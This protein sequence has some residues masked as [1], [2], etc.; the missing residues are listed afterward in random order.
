MA[1]AIERLR[2]AL[3]LQ[4]RAVEPGTRVPVAV[5]PEAT[6]PV[7][8]AE[9][10]L[11]SDPRERYSQ[12]WEAFVKLPEIVTIVDRIWEF[13]AEQLRLL[14]RTDA[15][16]VEQWTST[17]HL[18][19]LD[20]Q[21]YGKKS[22]VKKRAILKRRDALNLRIGQIP[23]AIEIAER[24]LETR[25]PQ[26]SKEKSGWLL[27]MAQKSGEWAI[28]GDEF[29]LLGF[30]VE[31]LT[32][33]EEVRERLFS[34]YAEKHNIDEA[35]LVN[36]FN[37]RLGLRSSANQRPE[38]EVRQANKNKSNVAITEVPDSPAS[39]IPESTYQRPT[40]FEIVLGVNQDPKP[41]SSVEELQG[42]MRKV[43]RMGEIRAVRIWD[44]VNNISRL[45]LDQIIRH[46]SVKA[47]TFKGWLKH[48]IGGVWHVIFRTKGDVLTF[49]VGHHQEVY[50]VRKRTGS[51]S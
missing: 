2:G 5:K 15:L 23:E 9:N 47:G 22:E 45:D 13:D 43:G 37:R 8:P 38:P 44:I 17:E 27:R 19:L 42:Y 3:N 29:R 24:E 20:R 33:N 34:L 32:A 26:V 21:L 14:G 46:E 41:V 1:S 50:G 31:N 7:V 51:G 18:A 40:K 35:S 36:R 4:V 49:R 30:A 39:K 48:P 10:P 12:E 25:L 6:T 28:S 11:S 16:K